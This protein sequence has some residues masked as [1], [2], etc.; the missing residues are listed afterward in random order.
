MINRKLEEKLGFENIRQAIKANCLSI[1]GR[2]MV[3]SIEFSSNFKTINQNLSLTEEFREILVTNKDFPSSNY[4]DLSDELNRLRLE[5]TFISQIKLFELKTSLITIRDCLHFFSHSQQE[6]YPFLKTLLENVYVDKQLI[7]SSSKIIDEKGEIN[8]NASTNLAILRS[9]KKKKIIEQDKKI[10]KLLSQAKKDGFSSEDAE[11]TIR[12]GRMVIPVFAANKRRISGLIQDE[13]ASG[14]TSYIEPSEIVEINNAVR[15][16]ELE[17]QREIIRI[18]TEFT[19]ILRCEIDTLL[20]A[21]LFLANIDFIQSKAKYALQIRAAKPI[22]NDETIIE[23]FDARHP[24]LEKTLAENQKKI[25]PLKVT[26]SEKERILVISGPNA[27]GKSVCL[28]TIGLLQYMIQCGIL[29]PLR[30]TSTVGVFN[31]IYID[32][33]DEQSL[34]N[35]LSTYSSH[36]LNMNMLCKKA[37]EKTLFL[38]DECGTGT[39]PLIGGAIAEAVLEY[40]NEKLSFGVVTT[41]YSNLKLLADKHEN[42]VNGAM[43]FD[44]RNLKP[45]YTL[46]IGQPGSSFAFEIA[47]TIGLPQSIIDSAVEKAGVSHIDFEE[48]LQKLQEDKRL[49]KKKQEQLKI[50]DDLLAE[51][52]EKYNR[53]KDKLEEDKTNIVK[54]AKQKA[55]E[56]IENANQ[57]VEN[58]IF[59]IKKANA[60]KEKTKQIREELNFKAEEIKKDLQK[61][62]SSQ[63]KK[64]K[65]KP[66][67]NN[68][69][70]NLGVKL[71]NSPLAI[72]DIVKLPYE[73]TFCQI[74]SIKRNKIEVISDSIKMIIDKQKVVKVDKKAFLKM[75]SQRGNKL[76]ERPSLSIIDEINEKR[77][78]FSSK[79]DLRG[80]RAEDVEDKVGKFIDQ[81]RLLG[82]REL[83]LLHGKGNGILKT[84]IREYLKNNPEVKSFRPANVEFGGE[85]ITLVSLY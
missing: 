53:L 51:V 56:I 34:E 66:I 59:N 31:S 28:K 1:S 54:E 68:N 80:E 25:V 27:G 39:D 63:T 41:H 18:L 61:M 6:E 84:I 35:D 79:L 46:A 11:V 74:I 21:Y 13:S 29:I 30:P 76:R 47:K 40:L 37:N 75:E 36:L 19:G 50:E 62:D 23:W 17:E 32:I 72:G 20:N 22:F 14:Q 60:D 58:T 3:D 44:Q 2:K 71:D 73:N 42:I 33:G 12:N 77:K 69:Y 48:Q 85:G 10:Q 4:F 78:F 55:K 38:I 67:T 7:I 45:L 16:L 57:V 65:E 52:L 26:L 64:A 70:E 24:L 8:D 49:L 82:E 83:S 81:A 5:G 43:L 9:T 15:E